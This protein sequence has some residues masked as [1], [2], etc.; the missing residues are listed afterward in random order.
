[1][2][3]NGSSGA[4]MNGKRQENFWRNTGPGFHVILLYLRRDNFIAVRK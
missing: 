2:R 3:L 4:V 1:M